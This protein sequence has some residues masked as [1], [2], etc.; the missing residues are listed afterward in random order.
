MAG[1]P[2]ETVK[3]EEEEMP[4][5]VRDAA[6]SED[7]SDSQASD[8]AIATATWDEHDRVYRCTKCYGEIDEGVCSWCLKEH[9]RFIP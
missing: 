3:E 6:G 2:E 9:V 1:S 7:D 4:V 8:E 5:D